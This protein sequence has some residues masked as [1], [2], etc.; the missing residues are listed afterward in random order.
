MMAI[1][2]MFFQDCRLLGMPL[3]TL[4]ASLD[5]ILC[6]CCITYTTCATWTT[7]T[8]AVTCPTSSIYVTLRT[9]TGYITHALHTFHTFHPFHYLLYVQDSRM[10]CSSMRYRTMQDNRI[11]T[12]THDSIDTEIGT[13][14]Y[15]H[16]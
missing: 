9:T 15:I 4:R 13:Y 14:R 1:I 12:I 3:H 11:H 2:G 16:A 6:K 10:Q 5:E 7:Y 8:T